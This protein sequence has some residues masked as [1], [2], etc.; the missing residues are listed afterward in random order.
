MIWIN[1][2]DKFNIVFGKDLLRATNQWIR[3]NY[4]KSIFGVM[5]PGD[6]DKEIIDVLDQLMDRPKPQ[7]KMN[8]VKR[9]WNI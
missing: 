3:D 7:N 5:K 4:K 8:G 1:L 2:E 9:I 6:I